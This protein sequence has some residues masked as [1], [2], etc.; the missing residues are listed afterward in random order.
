MIHGIAGDGVIPDMDGVIILLI[1]GV[2]AATTQAIRFTPFIHQEVVEIGTT[3][4][5]GQQVP[6]L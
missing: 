6:A 1:T 3:A 5:A 2:E 4:N